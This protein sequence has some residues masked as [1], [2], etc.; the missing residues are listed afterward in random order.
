MTVYEILTVGLI[1]ILAAA[2]VTAIYVGM[3]N[4]I[5]AAHVVRCMACH[6]LTFSGVNQPQPSCA[7]CRH[8]A[9]MHPIYSAHHPHQIRVVADQLRY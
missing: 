9:I 8:P 1:F 2:T 3:M 5:N 4:W 7:H 6:H